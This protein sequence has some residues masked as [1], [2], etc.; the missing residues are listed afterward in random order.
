MEHRKL[1]RLARHSALPL[2]A[3]ASLGAC[4]AAG[5]GSDAHDRYEYSSSDKA[6]HPIIGG[7]KATSYPESA[8]VDMYVN[9]KPVGV[10]SGVVIA[11][12]VVLTAGH[13][14]DGYNG[15]RVITPFAS[16]Q[17][18]VTKS[19][20][21]NYKKTGLVVDPTQQDVGLI[22]LTE[23]LLLATFPLVA[24]Q[25]LPA[26]SMVINVGRGRDGKSSD[27]DLSQGKA[28]AAAEASGLPNCYQTDQVIETDDSGGPAFLTGGAPHTII[29]VNA[30]I[31]YETQLIARTDLVASWIEQQ[32]DGHG[33]PGPS[34]TGGSADNGGSAGSSG[35]GG[36]PS[37]GGSAGAGG[38]SDQGGSTGT[39]GQPEQGGSGGEP[40]SGGSAG[41][42]DPGTAGQA[43]TGGPPDNGGDPTCDGAPEFEPNDSTQPQSAFPAMCGKIDAPDDEDWFVFGVS[44]AGVSYRI[45]SVGGDTE[46]LVWKMVDGSYYP[47]AN[48][49]P[50]I[51]ANTANGPGTYYI[52]V[53]SPSGSPGK[54]R[55]TLEVHNP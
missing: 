29:G 37:Q 35:T 32:V 3:S 5:A 34:G 47:I 18:R 11:P 7:T 36:E 30:A 40:N 46:I 10:C 55:L 8:L 2:I 27:H 45:E 50:A 51:V 19:A 21:T 54:Y 53:W 26:N 48:Q 6:S 25:Q 9:G 42:I 17:T 38:T 28:V 23:P 39:G 16:A 49:S 14:I 31:G 22:F 41:S 43:G 13:C 24:T 15:W 44:D 1:L 33:G 12:R 20:A 52:A 4:T